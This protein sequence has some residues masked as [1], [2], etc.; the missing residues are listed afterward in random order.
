MIKA[1][2][3]TTKAALIDLIAQIPFSTVLRPVSYLIYQFYLGMDIQLQHCRTKE[4]SD[5]YCFD[6][7]IKK[8]LLDDD[9]L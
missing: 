6:I 5:E 3:T 8:L 9:C 4:N 1:E 7:Q 2:T